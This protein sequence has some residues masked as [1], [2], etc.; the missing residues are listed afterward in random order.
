[1]DSKSQ[2]MHFY[3]L[4]KIQRK[5]CNH[6]LKILPT[7]LHPNM[8]TKG[9]SKVQASLLS[10][11]HCPHL[12]FPWF[13]SKMHKL[14]EYS[15]WFNVCVCVYVMFAYVHAKYPKQM[16]SLITIALYFRGKISHWPW[17]LLFPINWLASEALQYK[18]LNAGY[19]IWLLVGTGELNSGLNTCAANILPT[20]SSPTPW[21][22]ALK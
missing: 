8:I 15:K 21:I 19:H 5:H 3:L 16:T 6:T 17:S 14:G 11:F 12:T 2:L 13:P 10:F 9:C 20:K 7:S 18:V 1:M 4:K 22:I